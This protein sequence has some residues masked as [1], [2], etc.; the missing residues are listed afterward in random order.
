MFY[1]ITGT[2]ALLADWERS[3]YDEVMIHCARIG[4]KP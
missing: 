3:Q 4:F 2:G 1:S